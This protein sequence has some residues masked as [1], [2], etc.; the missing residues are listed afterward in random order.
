M[1]NGRARIE[2]LLT[3]RAIGGGWSIE[4]D[5]IRFDEAGESFEPYTF[6]QSFL[7]EGD[8]ERLATRIERDGTINLNLWIPTEAIDCQQRW[9]ED[10]VDDSW[11]GM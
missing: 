6:N 11:R 10:E 1:L 4:A 7:N 2:S 3:S 8:A 9:D 5:V